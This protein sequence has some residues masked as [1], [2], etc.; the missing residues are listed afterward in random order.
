M[1]ILQKDFRL[2][3]FPLLCLTFCLRLNIDS[4]VW[5]P[6]SCHQPQSS[7]SVFIQL[8]QMDLLQFAASY[9]SLFSGFLPDLKVEVTR[10]GRWM[11]SVTEESGDREK[12][13]R[14]RT[15]SVPVIAVIWQGDVRDWKAA[16]LL[17]AVHL[18][19]T[20]T[21]KLQSRNKGFLVNMNSALR[22]TVLLSWHHVL[23]FF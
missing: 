8:H 16:V 7:P 2:R 22:L 23:M 12:K 3:W 13:P 18:W 9:Q 19:R 21:L 4:T 14:R 11:E 10:G 17:L 1:S 15:G 5:S 20:Q 6:S